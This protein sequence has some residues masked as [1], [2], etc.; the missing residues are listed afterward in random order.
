MFILYI[1]QTTDQIPC[2][3]GHLGSIQFFFFFFVLGEYFGEH[4]PLVHLF[5][6]LEV[7]IIVHNYV[8][9]YQKCLLK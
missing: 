7:D 8:N 5:D 9:V 6:P 2:R 1:K 3:E 4:L